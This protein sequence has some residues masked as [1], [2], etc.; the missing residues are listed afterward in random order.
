[1]KPLDGFHNRQRTPVDSL[2]IPDSKRPHEP[3]EA[4]SKEADRDN[5]ENDRCGT[6]RKIVEQLLCREYS[7]RIRD[8]PGCCSSD[9]TDRMLLETERPRIH[10]LDDSN[11]PRQLALLTSFPPPRLELVTTGKESG[12]GG[13]EKVGNK[14]KENT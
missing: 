1:M 11:P 13:T 4:T 6:Q 7:R 10:K 8:V 9:H 14:N 2:D 5:A 3:T 12:P